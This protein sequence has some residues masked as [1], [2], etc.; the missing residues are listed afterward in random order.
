MP[1]PRT[2]DSIEREIDSA[3]PS[4]AVKKAVA[5]DLEA[6]LPAD[7]VSGQEAQEPMKTSQREAQDDEPPGN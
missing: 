1:S 4:A 3:E 6:H 7:M 5:E 2:H